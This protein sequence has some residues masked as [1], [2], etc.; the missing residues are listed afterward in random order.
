MAP[1]PV[2]VVGAAG[3]MGRIAVQGIH[4][5]ADLNL[6][7]AVDVTHVDEDAGELA[8]IGTIDVPITNDFKTMLMMCAQEREPGVVLDFTRA[9]VAYENVRESIAFG[10]RPVVGTTGLTPQQLNE[11]SIFADKASTGCI[12]APNFALG[13]ILLQE[14]CSR[15][16]QFFDHVELI[17]LHHNEKADAPSGTALKTAHM[18]AGLGK[19][20]NATTFEEKELLLGARGAVSEDGIRI[21]SVRLPGLIAHQEVIFGGPGQTLTLR[22]DTSHRTAYIPGILLAIRKVRQL[23]SLVYGL[24]KIL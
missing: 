19:A 3:K 12:I 11:L 18:M 14:A 20:F 15:I 1:I 2:V 22:H 10:I 5:A 13:M 7:A 8:G 21:H 16:A 6:M 23:K 17:E 24:E 4:E 9:D